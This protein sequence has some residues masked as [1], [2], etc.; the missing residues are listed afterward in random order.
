MPDKRNEIISMARPLKSSEADH[1]GSELRIA[2]GALTQAYEQLEGRLCR[3]HSS[4]DHQ[5]RFALNLLRQLDFSNVIS[6]LNTVCSFIRNQGQR[7]D[8]LA[9]ATIPIL[10]EI[11]AAY[12]MPIPVLFEQLFEVLNDN[13]RIV[14]LFFD[15]CL[16]S[17]DR[18]VQTVDKNSFVRAQ[19][20]LRR[21]IS[22]RDDQIQKL[23]AQIDQL[24]KNAERVKEDEVMR[25]KNAELQLVLKKAEERHVSAI[26]KLG[27]RI[28]A[29]E[30]Q[31]RQ[32]EDE[33]LTCKETLTGVRHVLSRLAMDVNIMKEQADIPDMSELASAILVSSETL[34][35]L[36]NESKDFRT[37]LKQLSLQELTT[38]SA[39]LAAVQHISLRNISTALDALNIQ[40]LS[41]SF[42]RRLA[43]I[44]DRLQ[45]LTG[46][47]AALTRKNRELQKQL[48]ERD[49]LIDQLR[50]SNVE[51][52]SVGNGG[53]GRILQQAALDYEQALAERD[54]AWAATVEV[55]KKEHKERLRAMREGEI[56]KK[57]Q[58][59]SI[60]RL[61]QQHE[62]TSGQSSLAKKMKRTLLCDSQS[63]AFKV[64]FCGI[65]STEESTTMQ[66]QLQQLGA[67]VLDGPGIPR[68]TTHL[69]TPHAY[70]SPR[71]IYGFFSGRW[72]V[73]VDWVADS[74][75]A[76][77][78]LAESFYGTRVT[79]QK[80]RLLQ[81]IYYS[82]AF[83]QDPTF[84]QLVL[85]AKCNRS[86]FVR[87]DHVEPAHRSECVVLLAEEEHRYASLAMSVSEFLE[88]LHSS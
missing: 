55:L 78:L 7:E 35:C 32:K 29:L 30:T 46:H 86:E 41:L 63:I 85:V 33:L 69:V 21:T 51:L 42:E 45:T 43:Y 70:A 39:T 17:I 57:A 19:N 74:A 48:C 62:Q 22:H 25:Q 68:G 27:L 73:N 3:S 15:D 24:E 12:L 60:C 9:K 76:G 40:Q 49:L 72:V 64:V 4:L 80:R 18:L 47:N 52:E 37:G 59:G 65:H 56:P 53:N 44:T 79:E 26:S 20:G 13:E 14:N 6:E 87:V 81:R 66:I 23:L 36:S 88:W 83:E 5:N 75:R 61:S 67:T 84:S 8:L 54:D 11:V 31:A 28:K 38:A 1:F 34:L 50:T 2:F 77:K 82:R 58:S 16:P 71:S 10:N